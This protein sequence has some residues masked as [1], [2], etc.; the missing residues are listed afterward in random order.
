MND[1]HSYSTIP[2][3]NAERENTKANEHR[4]PAHVNYQKIK[5]DQGSPLLNPN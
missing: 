2:L 3:R 5:H 4:V 1:G